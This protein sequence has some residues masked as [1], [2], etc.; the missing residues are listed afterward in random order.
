MGG[1]NRD[2]G[3]AGGNTGQSRD[4]HPMHC[5]DQALTA[6]VRICGVALRSGCT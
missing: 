2:K 5:G 3:A 6:L 1:F 4:G